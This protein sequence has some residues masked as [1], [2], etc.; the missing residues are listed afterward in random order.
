[1]VSKNER[2]KIQAAEAERQKR[3]WDRLTARDEATG[4]AM[5]EIARVHA[6]T[7]DP[8]TM[9]FDELPEWL[10]G[11]IEECNRKAKAAAH[12]AAEKAAEEAFD[13]TYVA[14]FKEVL[15]AEFNI[16]SAARKGN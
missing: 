10:A 2:A 14:A 11:T 5:H 6:P 3:L 4:N 13:A 7:F 16:A 8:E 1:M 9:D 15:E 12:K